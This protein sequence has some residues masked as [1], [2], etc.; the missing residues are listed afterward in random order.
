VPSKKGGQSESG[1][2]AHA[3]PGRDLR[4]LVNSGANLLVRGEKSVAAATVVAL[5][6][7]FPPPLLTWSAA[8]D[9]GLPALDRGTLVIH[10]VD[11]LD[12]ARQRA[13][14]IWLE[15]R[16]NRVRVITTVT[17]DLFE[18]VTAGDFLDQL[19]YRLNTII[20]DAVGGDRQASPRF[21]IASRLPGPRE[22]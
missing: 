2:V 13:L 7:D 18:L 6:A 15:H 5:S 17:R 16:T 22:S 20:I 9:T 8:T 19:Y 1:E 3:I 21:T 4:R 10:D 14:L 11:G 12:L